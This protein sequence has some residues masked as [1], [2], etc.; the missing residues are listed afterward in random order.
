MPHHDEIAPVTQACEPNRAASRSAQ[1]GPVVAEEGPSHD[2]R[3]TIDVL[4]EGTPRGRGAAGSK[5]QAEQAAARE[6][7][8]ALR[9]EETT[10]SPSPRA[11]ER[12]S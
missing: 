11:T 5:K 3:F 10:P 2:R 6:A 12:A 8:D 1:D 4:V 9:R 7:L